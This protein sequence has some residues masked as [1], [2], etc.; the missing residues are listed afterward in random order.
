ML[1]VVAIGISLGNWQLRRAD[2]KRAIET[3]LTA[4]R[5]QAPLVLGAAPVSIDELE[6]RRVMVQ[7]EFDRAWPL[8]LDNRPIAGNAGFYLLMPFKIAGSERHVLVAR[9]WIPVDV[10]N[11]NKLPP[12][13]APVGQVEIEGVA[14]RNPGHIMQ[15]GQATAVQPGAILQNLTVTEFAAASKFEMQ[16]FVLEQSNDT[17][18]GM[19]REWPRPSVGIE[20]HL[21]YAFQ[22]YA[23][24]LTAFL[25]FV[26]TGYRR[27]T[28]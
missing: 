20:R 27:G 18:D 14:I 23:L 21:G 1:V 16:P 2:E 17:H 12:T 13:N 4:R 3:R 8:Y 7:G 9:G 15:L 10:H 25:F 19:L 11:R 28:K 26:V 24:A 22:W 6:Y 5:A